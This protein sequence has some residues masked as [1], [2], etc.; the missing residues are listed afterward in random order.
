MC[1]YFSYNP[2]NETQQET[3]LKLILEHIINFISYFK[4][5]Q[6][7]TIF[8]KYYLIIVVEDRL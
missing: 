6:I 5:Y 2:E 3:C 7:P 4:D 8:F 1:F